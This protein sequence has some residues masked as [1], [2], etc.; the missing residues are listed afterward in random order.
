ME[1]VPRVFMYTDRVETISN[2]ITERISC[3]Q[4]WV[5]EFFQRAVLKD[6]HAK[7]HVVCPPI[8]SIFS[9]TNSTIDL[10]FNYVR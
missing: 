1:L 6:A 10:A 3:T 9:R 8:Y 5:D 2:N 7:V 4:V